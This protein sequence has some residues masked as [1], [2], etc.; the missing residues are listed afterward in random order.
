M[1]HYSL[2]AGATMLLTIAATGPSTAQYQPTQTV[3]FVVHGGPGSGNDAFA[4]AIVQM[5]E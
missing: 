1:K 3:E 2:L 5:I 4:R